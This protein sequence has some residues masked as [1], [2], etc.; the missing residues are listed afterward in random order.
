MRREP[1]LP[2]LRS[3][4]RSEHARRLRRR[5]RRQYRA[6]GPGS[7]ATCKCNQS[8]TSTRTLVG[9]KRA[10]RT[11]Y[12]G[13]QGAKVTLKIDRG[14]ALSIHEI[15]ATLVCAAAVAAPSAALASGPLETS[16]AY[17]ADVVSSW[18]DASHGRAVALDSL[19]FAG[20]AD[21]SRIVGLGGGSVHFDLN[22]TSGT[23]PNDLAGTLQGIDNIEVSR[24]RLRLYELW[25][26]QAV[27]DGRGSLRVGLQEINEEFNATES[28]GL[29]VNPSFGLGPEL[30]AT[31]VNGPSTYPSTALAVRARMVAPSGLDLRLGAFNAVAASPNDPGGTDYAFNSGV[32]LIG[33]ATLRTW[34]AISLGVWRYSDNQ[35]DLRDTD[36]LGAPIKRRSEGIYALVEKT[37]WGAPDDVRRTTAFVRMGAADGDTTPFAGSWQTGLVMERPIGAREDSVLSAG[38]AQ[39]VTSA[40]HR[41]NERDAGVDAGPSETVV[42]FTYS[43]KV[44]RWLTVQP[45]IQ[46]VVDPG[47]DRSR[48]AAL[49]AGVRLTISPSAN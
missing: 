47:A 41:A 21:L 39:A 28:S 4:T 27:S 46:F 29:L 30:G 43:D 5:A 3:H 13:D 19:H 15:G 38:V 12:C 26:E 45:D 1:L 33:E 44:T 34:G 36:S 23:T 25:Y 10:A 14:P 16:L 37:L 48:D 11:R 6:T 17:Q 31:G 40:K 9:Q 7:P 32:L 2:R 24:P 49:T 35:N 20:D 18:S 8:S 22:S 42:E